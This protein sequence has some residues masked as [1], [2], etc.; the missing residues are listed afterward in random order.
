MLLYRLPKHHDCP[1]QGD[2]SVPSSR[3][4]VLI[5]GEWLGLLRVYN[6]P[7][8]SPVTSKGQALWE[9]TKAI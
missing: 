8:L 1:I 3:D 9:N 2:Y 5:D 4:S 7:L 6:A